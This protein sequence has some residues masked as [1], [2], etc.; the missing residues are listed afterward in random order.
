M[1]GVLQIIYILLFEM[2]YMVVLEE[3]YLNNGLFESEFKSTLVMHRILP[4]II[5]RNFTSDMV[6]WIVDCELLLMS[7]TTIFLFIFTPFLK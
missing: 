5:K 2:L 3:T 7:Q 1:F 6:D 4:N